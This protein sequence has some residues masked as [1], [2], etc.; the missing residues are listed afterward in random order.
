M[1]SL[2]DWL[3]MRQDPAF[4]AAP[5][6]TGYRCWRPFWT[7]ADAMSLDSG[8]KSLAP[9]DSRIGRCIDFPESKRKN[10]RKLLRLRRT[11]SKACVSAQDDSARCKSRGA[12]PRLAKALARDDR[13]V[14]RSFV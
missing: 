14:Q 7:K 9:D 5:L 3:V 1:A 2:P 6:L 4:P 10:R 11:R 8:L 13:Q 12:V